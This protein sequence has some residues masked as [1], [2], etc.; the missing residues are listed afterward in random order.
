M[1]SA[2]RK[3]IIILFSYQ[4]HESPMQTRSTIKGSDMQGL[5]VSWSGEKGLSLA[6]EAKLEQKTRWKSTVPLDWI[7]A[8]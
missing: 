1:S 3:D 6:E 8:P 7:A 2:Q 4:D 5:L